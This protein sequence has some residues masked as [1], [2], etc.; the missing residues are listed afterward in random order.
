MAVDSNVGLFSW[1]PLVWRSS[2]DTVIAERDAALAKLSRKSIR[3]AN[4][5]TKPIPP[6]PDESPDVAEEG[7]QMADLPPVVIEAI[8]AR[9]GR[10][11]R[12]LG[13]MVSAAQKAMADGATAERVA[14]FMW[15]GEPE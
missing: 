14:E 6:P 1:W 9:A 4:K 5:L 11:S 2:Y 7:T 15:R 12:A 13:M 8:E 10:N 3:R